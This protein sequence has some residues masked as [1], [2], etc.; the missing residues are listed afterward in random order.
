MEK[1]EFPSYVELVDNYNEWY[2]SAVF[3]EGEEGLRAGLP[4]Y[5]TEDAVL[6]EAE[7]LPQGGTYR[8]IEGWIRFAEVAKVAWTPIMHALEVTGA[9]HYQSGNIVFREIKFIF[10]P[11]AAAPEPFIMGIIEK[12]TITDGRISEID[13]FYADTA[14]LNAR[15]ATLGVL[16]KKK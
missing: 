15:L 4:Q 11:T 14:G 1:D 6:Y 12:Y 3:E 9:T 8:G 13:E 16:P 5:I 10:A 2:L 7:S